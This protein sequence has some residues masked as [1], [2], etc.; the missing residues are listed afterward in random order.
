[1]KN[2]LQNGVKNNSRLCN[3]IG[4]LYWV[5]YFQ[6]LSSRERSTILTLRYLNSFKRITINP[7][8]NI[9]PNKA[10]HK[11]F[12]QNSKRNRIRI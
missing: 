8:H 9:R 6:N 5:N 12:C 4:Y 2:R 7:R 3:R 10:Y 1:M 11:S